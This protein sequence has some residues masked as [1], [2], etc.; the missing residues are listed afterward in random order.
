MIELGVILNLFLLIPQ[1]PNKKKRKSVADHKKLS[2]ASTIM[3]FIYVCDTKNVCSIKLV[4]CSLSNYALV[5]SKGH[6]HKYIF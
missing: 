5:V 1:F 6:K 4:V 3:Y 2:H